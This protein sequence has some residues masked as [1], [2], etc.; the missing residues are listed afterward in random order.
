M[1]YLKE[2]PGQ[3]SPKA[4][5]DVIDRLEIIRKLNLNLN[6]GGIHPNRVRQLARLGSKY[7]PHSF[8][9]FEDNKRYAML[10]LYLYDLSQSLID[11]AIDIYYKQINTL[12]SNGRKDQ[13]EI[14]KVLGK[15]LNEKV[16]QFVDIGVALIKAKNE[17][18]D[19]FKAI[20]SVMPWDKMVESVEEAKKLTRPGN[21]DYLDLIDSRYNQLRKYTPSLVK[22]FEFSSTNKSLEPLV[23]AI[24][25]L[26]DMNEN[27]KR[28]VP[29]NAPV[30]FIPNRWN[31]YVFEPEGTINRHYYEMVALTE[32]KNKIRSGD[33]A[34]TG[35]R[36][37]KK[38]QEYLIT[39][40]E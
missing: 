38:F 31:K 2:D 16:I 39:K 18:L 4:F 5:L 40:I 6:I 34:V 15:S 8:R 13:E 12:L 37:Y 20:E 17:K 14:Q 27:K 1:A 35:S 7:E 21:Y 25:V 29:D 22:Y 28:K 10:A 30:S 32:L 11:L 33:I 3:S 19:P 26:N 36:N 9:R 24:K 23:E